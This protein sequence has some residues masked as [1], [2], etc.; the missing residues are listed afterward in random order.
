MEDENTSMDESFDFDQTSGE[1]I[2]LDHV[3]FKDD[4]T[5]YGVSCY[6]PIPEVQT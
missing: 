2:P 3:E 4:H 6:G 1:Y 5:Y